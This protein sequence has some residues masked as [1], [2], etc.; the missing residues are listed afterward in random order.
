M[1]FRGTGAVAAVHG[2][3]DAP[4]AAAGTELDAAAR[5]SRTRATN[6]RPIKPNGFATPS[7]THGDLSPSRLHVT[8]GGETYGTIFYGRK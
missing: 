5:A 2:P 4:N 1:A 6:G 8:R 3:V 7:A